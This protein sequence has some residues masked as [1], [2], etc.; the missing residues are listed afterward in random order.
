LAMK[1]FGQLFNLP[2]KA[3]FTSYSPLRLP[4]SRLYHAVGL[5]TNITLGD[6]VVVGTTLRT[7]LLKAVLTT[8][9][10]MAE[11]TRSCRTWRMYALHPKW[12]IP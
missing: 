7:G 2:L 4:L 12:V 5:V 11:S 9:L 1:N 6:G 3:A 10:G 8:R